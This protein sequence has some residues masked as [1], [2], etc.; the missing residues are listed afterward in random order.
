M[1]RRNQQL[2]LTPNNWTISWMPIYSAHYRKRKMMRKLCMLIGELKSST[3]YLSK[4]RMPSKKQ[5]WRKS[6][7]D[8]IISCKRLTIRSSCSSPYSKQKCRKTKENSFKRKK[9]PW[10]SSLKSKRSSMKRKCENWQKML[11]KESNRRN[12]KC[13]RNRRLKE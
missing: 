2:M 10:K 6:T 11:W 13:W 12:D 7:P 8:F 9:P 4:C 3:D 5:K 1:A